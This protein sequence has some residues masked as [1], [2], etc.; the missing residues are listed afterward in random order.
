MRWRDIDLQAKI[1]RIKDTKN[2]REHVLPIPSQLYQ[3]FAERKNKGANDWVFPGHKH[4]SPIAEPRV[5]TRIVETKSGVKTNIHDLRRT[6][7]TVAESLDIPVYALKRLLNHK[8]SSDVTNGYI[9]TDVERL[10]R[11]MQQ[12][13]DYLWSVMSATNGNNVVELKVNSNASA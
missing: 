7:A 4:N 11:P 3:L 1:L 9:I 10:R 8:D 5:F 12:I 13:A 2:G 6:F